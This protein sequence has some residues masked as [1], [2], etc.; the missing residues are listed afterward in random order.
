MKAILRTLWVVIV[1]EILVGAGLVWW[2]VRQPQPPLP[3]LQRLDSVTAAELRQL[4]DETRRDNTAAMWQTLGDGYVSFGYFPEA[5]AC[6]RQAAERGTETYELMLRWG[7]CLDRLGH[8]SEAI[9]M[10]QRA[11]D[12]SQNHERAVCMYH[13][14][15]CAMREE[16]AKRSEELL[17]TADDFP[18]ARYQ[19]A[20]LLLRTER[21]DEAMPLLDE[22]LRRYP[23]E[24]KLNWL[25]AQAETERGDDD[26]AMEYRERA[27]RSED[28]LFLD[29]TVEFLGVLRINFGLQR[30]Q[31]RC[32]Q[33]VKSGQHDSAA[34]C[35]YE[36][37]DAQWDALVIRELVRI[38]LQRGRVDDAR[39]LLTD[40]TNRVGHSPTSW[41]L[42][43]DAAILQ[44]QAGEATSCWEQAVELRPNARL[45]MKLADVWSRRGEEVKAQYHRAR[46][47]YELGLAAFRANDLLRALKHFSESVNHEPN[48][49]HVW[50]YLAECQRIL[51]QRAVAS[52]SYRRCLDLDAQHGRASVALE[53]MANSTEER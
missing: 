25:R 51:G 43:G 31:N 2:R 40:L 35:L 6:Y 47:A 13:A 37:I 21:N 48:R 24:L 17:R 26:A 32:F 28:R 5:D 16:D 30:E 45:H 12:L 20:K 19:L 1:L 41:E 42:R 39:E 53:R 9:K 3:N 44:K 36:L 29:S 34:A 33:L 27:D 11:A 52:N 14:A 23:N 8:T 46:E 15:R 10:Y 4:Y 18:L 50:F 38:E 49:A 22:L 7:V